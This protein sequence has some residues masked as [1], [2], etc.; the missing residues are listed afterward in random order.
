ML[1]SHLPEVVSD[2]LVNGDTEFTC[3]GSC[4]GSKHE[5]A[6]VGGVNN[7][8]LD[9]RR[10]CSQSSELD[11]GRANNRQ[12]TW[13]GGSSSSRRNCCEVDGVRAA[14]EPTSKDGK[15]S[16]AEVNGTPTCEA[17]K[18]L[19]T[20]KRGLLEMGGEDAGLQPKK[21]RLDSESNPR[22]L[23]DTRTSRCSQCCDEGVCSQLPRR[24]VQMHLL[25]Q[26]L[27]G[28]SH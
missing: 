24:R 19:K 14:G 17:G 15:G 13:K 7:G 22:H 16:K 11:E 27:T 25:M 20:R 1:Q 5:A 8:Q 26:L 6:R 28:V 2:P 10:R 23:E 18:G 21:S 4:R 12:P 3:K 9:S